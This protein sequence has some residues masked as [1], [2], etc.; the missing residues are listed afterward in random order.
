MH[1]IT[2]E[3]AL[4]PLYAGWVREMLSG[5]VPEETRATCG[6]CAMRPPDGQPEGGAG[7]FHPVVK[8]CTY[9]PQIPNFL[10]GGILRDA[11][12]A[13]EYGRTTFLERMRAGDGVTPLG[14]AIPRRN[15]IPAGRYS[16]FLCWNAVSPESGTWSVKRIRR[17]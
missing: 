7:Y 16:N 13:L 6:D 1:E 2:Q 5:P 3:A 15:G 4:P 11:D 14:L 12:P 9:V 8:C 17:A 10:A